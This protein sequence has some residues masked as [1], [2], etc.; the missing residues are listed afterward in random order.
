MNIEEAKQQIIENWDGY[1]KLTEELRNNKELILLAISEWGGNNDGPLEFVTDYTLRDDKEIA[2]QAV[3]GNQFGGTYSLVSDRLKKDR[4][5]I[6]ESVKY[7]A[8]DEGLKKLLAKTVDR[9]IADAAVLGQNFQYLSIDFKNDRE[10]VKTAVQITG[11]SLQSASKVL[12]NDK[13]IVL[14][15]IGKD[16]WAI[17]YVSKSLTGDL[18]VAIAA[19]TEDNRVLELLPKP[20]R[21]NESIINACMKESKN[22]SQNKGYGY[23]YFG[24]KFQNDR[25]ITLKMSKGEGFSLE[26]APDKFKKDKEIVRNAIKTTYLNIKF[27]SPELMGDLDFVRELYNLNNDITNYLSEEIKGKILLTKVTSQVHFDNQI[28]MEMV[29]EAG[30]IQDY[31]IDAKAVHV[32]HD[33]RKV[34]TIRDFPIITFEDNGPVGSYLS[35][36]CFNSI[37]L[38]GPFVFYISKNT[39]RETWTNN[40]QPETGWGPGPQPNDDFLKHKVY[41]I[42][43]NNEETKEIDFA[44]IETLGTLIYYGKENNLFNGISIFR[45]SDQKREALTILN[46]KKVIGTPAFERIGDNQLKALNNVADEISGAARVYIDNLGWRWLLPNKDG[47]LAALE[48]ARNT[49]DADDLYWI[50]GQ[51]GEDTIIE[52][53][54]KGY[55]DLVKS[56]INS[57]VDPN[58]QNEFRGTVL[59]CA[60][61]YNNLEIVK[62]LISAGA[63][64][65]L[66]DS[67]NNY[68]IINASLTN[69][70]DMVRILINAK[71]DV[72]VFNNNGDTALIW[73]SCNNNPKMVKLLIE[74]GADIDAK[75]HTGNTALIIAASGGYI[76]VVELLMAAGADIGI[77][78]LEGK[79][80]LDWADQNGQTDVIPLLKNAGPKASK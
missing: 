66:N 6:I 46:Q 19:V 50:K 65:D 13:E 40:L 15:A 32:I 58:T 24:K 43:L 73:A 53:T 4:D 62:I 80:A 16:P 74:A 59:T 37:V 25:D 30:Y 78:S 63:N 34:L 12:K 61:S 33:G 14:L 38:S 71:A 45:D 23:Q 49:S 67:D 29:F 60:S 54:E 1:E 31:Q 68:G 41:L 17:R 39:G 21:N 52:A 72:N 42:D 5:V 48:V 69:N 28:V 18:D 56:L 76:E 3:K 2:I 55:V 35:E 7:P 9:D 51:L 10:I 22:E 36:R 77:V 11:Q 20:F 44:E 26:F 27:V 8:H 75:S 47:A 70:L 57:G 79:T 64:V